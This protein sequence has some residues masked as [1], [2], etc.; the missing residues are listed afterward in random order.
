MKKLLTLFTSSLLLSSA[1]TAADISVEGAYARATAPGQ[2]NSAVFMQIGNGGDATSL[3]GASS[4]AAQVVELHA[5]LH[6]QG[7]MRMRKI[8]AIELPAKSQIELAPG[9]LHIMLIGLESPLKAGS[10]IDMVLEFADGTSE[11]LM[12]PVQHVMPAGMG[13]GQSM[14]HDKRN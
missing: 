1:A 7:V 10:Q 5:H 4:H 11:A 3:V 14:S 8:D 2:P 13:H 6:D 9:G 12:V